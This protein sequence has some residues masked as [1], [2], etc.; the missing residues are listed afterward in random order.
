MSRLPAVLFSDHNP[1]RA[2]GGEELVLRQAL[3]GLSARGW[4][5][6]L[7]YHEWGDL[8]PEY[9]AAGI[10]CRQFDLTQARLDSPWRFA[11]SVARQVLWAR[12]ERVELYHCNSYFRAAH[13]AAVKRLGGFPAICHFHIPSPDYLSRQYRWGLQQLEGLIAVSARTAS[14]WSR[15]LQVPTGRIDVLHNP[16]DTARFRPD[17]AARKS[18]RCEL[19]VGD[20][21]VVI[22]YCGRLIREKGVDVLIRALARLVAEKRD[23]KLVV[24]GSDGQ[25]VVLHGEPLEPKLKLLAQELGVAV[26]FLGARP[27]VERWYNAMDIV[28]APSVYSEPFGLVVAE[29]LAC[30]RPVIASRVGGIP[31]IMTGP[32]DEYLVPPNDVEALAAILRR[33]IGDPQRRA[34]A[35]RIGRDTVDNNFGIALFLDRLEQIFT[36]ILA[37]QRSDQAAA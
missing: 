27:D 22:G 21:C 2:N 16:I 26:A 15:T 3:L 8:V 13:A 10:E 34:Q 35:G 32:L 37:S 12:R 9:Q 24:L 6:L 33:L 7:A 30:G 14:E 20:D 29:A 28:V 5:C 25:N 11:S 23:L 36:R 19:G 31:E 4:R 17:A 18:T 1:S